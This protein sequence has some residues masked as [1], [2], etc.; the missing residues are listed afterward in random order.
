MPRPSPAVARSQ[1]ARARRERAEWLWALATGAFDIM[2]SIE[3][4]KSDPASPLRN[5]SLRSLLEARFSR[6]RCEQIIY[7][8]GRT[9][10][11]DLGGRYVPV[12][13][14]F[15][16]RSSGERLVALKVLLEGSCEPGTPF[17]PTWPGVGT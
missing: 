1:L 14:L 9:C 3:V 6:R 8:L 2:D 17:R 4:A 5:M 13:W 7:Q 15:D 12:R 10:G 16:G 11:H